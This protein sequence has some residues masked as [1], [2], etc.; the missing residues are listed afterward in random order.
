[1]RW[2]WE[3]Y[4]SSRQL[5]YGSLLIQILFQLAWKSKQ[6]GLSKSEKSVAKRNATFYCIQM[7]LVMSMCL[8]SAMIEMARHVL[9]TFFISAE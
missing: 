7:S 4:Q 2:N 6:S 9:I 5:L 1:M 8:F 3:E